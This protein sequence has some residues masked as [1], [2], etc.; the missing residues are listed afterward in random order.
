MSS[1]YR[2][3]EIAQLMSILLIAQLRQQR[4]GICQARGAVGGSGF[5]GCASSRLEEV[6]FSFFHHF[7]LEYSHF[8]IEVLLVYT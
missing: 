4:C 7:T 3:N 2:A 6:C 8:K 5:E 1:G